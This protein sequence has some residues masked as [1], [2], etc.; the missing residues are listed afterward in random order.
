M[1][2]PTVA[3]APLDAGMA[4]DF[5]LEDDVPFSDRLTRAC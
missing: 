5:R 4:I 3:E 2:P 1:Y